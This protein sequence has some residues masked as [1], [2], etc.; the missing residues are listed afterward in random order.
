[1]TEQRASYCNLPWG[2]TVNGNPIPKG[3]PR[4][5]QGRAMTPARTREYETLVSQAAGIAWSGE[6]AMGDL[7]VTLRFYRANR[8]RCD[9]DNLIKS[10]ADSL[11]G[12]IWDDDDQ[13]VELH[14]TKNY[15]KDRPRVE[16]TVEPA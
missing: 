13:I 14:A 4:V 10:V 3:R 16:I 1:M 8:I 7:S 5:Y 15:D 2:L 12:V 11:N 9:I 6:P